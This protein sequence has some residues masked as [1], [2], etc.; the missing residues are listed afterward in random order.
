M[1][2]NR[3]L[4]MLK[5]AIQGMLYYLLYIS[6]QI[7][8]DRASILGIPFFLLILAI[9]TIAVLMVWSSYRMSKKPH[10]DTI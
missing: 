8:T 2:L 5:I 3:Y 4:F 10:Q 6:I 9:I 1:I 7:A